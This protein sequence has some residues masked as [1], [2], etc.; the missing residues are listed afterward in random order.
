MRT[1][2]QIDCRLDEL[3]QEVED[4]RLDEA[5]G[6]DLYSWNIGFVFEGDSLQ[7]PDWGETSVPTL[8]SIL[9][10]GG[11]IGYPNYA[12]SGQTT[13]QM[14]SQYATQGALSK[15]EDNELKWYSVEGGINDMQAGDSAAD[16][17]GRLTVLYALSRADGYKVLAWTLHDWTDDATKIT[18]TATINAWILAHPELYDKV[19]RMDQLFY[20]YADQSAEYVD[21]IHPNATGRGRLVQAI[22]D[23]VPHGPPTADKFNGMFPVSITS[24]NITTTGLL[25]IER[26]TPSGYN[27]INFNTKDIGGGVTRTDWQFGPHGDNNYQIRQDG[28]LRTKWDFVTTELSHVGPFVAQSLNCINPYGGLPLSV[29]S[30]FSASGSVG[31][32]FAP[33]LQNGNYVFMSVGRS[34]GTSEAALFGLAGAGT[35]P[36]V[37]LGIAGRSSTDFRIMPTGNI[38]LGNI[39]D[40]GHRLSVDGVIAA[41]VDLIAGRGLRIMAPVVPATAA[42]TGV[43]GDVAWDASFLYVC[44]ATNTWKRTALTTW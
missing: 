39:P 19:L 42:S 41:N 15:P 32:L 10:N 27:K 23:L 1:I 25:T 21:R 11:I 4:L 5:G 28:V 9:V 7:T 18:K 6:S 35:S 17:I 38:I 12:V 31:N 20:S 16:I 37:F 3:G 14:V 22:Y 2:K 36:Y 33:S 34:L 40:Y 30:N 13:T 44:V 29:T 24:P 8:L 43:A 26:A